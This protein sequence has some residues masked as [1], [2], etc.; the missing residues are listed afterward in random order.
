MRRELGI[1]A[2]GVTTSRKK[3]AVVAGKAMVC[4]SRAK[5]RTCAAGGT[6][7]ILRHDTP[8]SLASTRAANPRS[9]LVDNASVTPWICVGF[10]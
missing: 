3:R 5:R 4:C 9:S 2:A 6:S 10:S 1:G 7:A 8:S